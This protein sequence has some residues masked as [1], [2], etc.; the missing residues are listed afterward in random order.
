M[1]TIMYFSKSISGHGTQTS[2][3]YL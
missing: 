3:C 2:S 1:A